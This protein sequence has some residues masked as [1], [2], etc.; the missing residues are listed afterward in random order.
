MNRRRAARFG[1]VQA[2]YQLELSGAPLDQVLGEFHAYRLADLL[3]PLEVEGAPPAVDREWFHAVT[4]GAWRR[5][6][7]LDPLIA[8]TLASGWSLERLG[9]LLRSLLRAG[10]FELADRPDVPPRVVVDEYTSLAHGFL[11]PDD[12]G[13]VNAALDRLA[14]RLRPPPEAAAEPA[15]G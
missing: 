11:E 9:Y 10:A 14:K 8:S 12:A 6:A 4:A 5:A 2:L 7:E 1:A 13:F 15:D 3:E